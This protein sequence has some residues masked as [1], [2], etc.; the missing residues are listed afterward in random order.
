MK[1]TIEDHDGRLRLRWRYQGNRFT[2]G[3]GVPS[4]P[5]GMAV[6]RMKQA[7]IERDLINGYFELL[8][9]NGGANRGR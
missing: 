6:A 4:T 9:D 7:Q 1:V 2:L 3:C 8:N 5:T